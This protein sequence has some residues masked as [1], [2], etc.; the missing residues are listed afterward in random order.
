MKK[1]SVKSI[2]AIGIGAALFFVLGRFVSIPSPVP[3]TNI[4]VQYGLLAFLAVVYG[5]VA[6]ALIGFIL[7][8]NTTE[9]VPENAKKSLSIQTKKIQAIL[10]CGSQNQN[11]NLRQ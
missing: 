5:P 3:N 9:K 4:S 1:F 10:F 8:L 11:L 6:G 2:V 7:S